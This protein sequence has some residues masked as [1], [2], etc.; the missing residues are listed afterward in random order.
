MKLSLFASSLLV[1][2]TALGTVAAVHQP[3]MAQARP[4][5]ETSFVCRDFQG[6]PATIAVTPRGEVVMI[7]WTKAMGDF[8]PQVRCQTV[9]SRFQTAYSNKTLRFLTSGL[10]NGQ[11]VICVAQSRA[12]GCSPNGLLFTLRPADNH[13]QVLANLIGQSRYASAPAV[14][15][16]CVPKREYNLNTDI[17]ID[18]QEFLYQCPDAEQEA[19][20]PEY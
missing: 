12:G 11:R 2:S 5:Q 13:R 4:T 14:I 16:N 3:V 10:M 7:R 20:K 9:S 1:T 6:Q 8:D 19:P 15:Q 18:F 17:T